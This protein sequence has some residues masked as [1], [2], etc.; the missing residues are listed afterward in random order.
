MAQKKSITPTWDRTE[1][2]AVTSCSLY[3]RSSGG[4]VSGGRLQKDANKWSKKNVAEV[5]LEPT[6]SKRLELE[7]SA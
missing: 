2:L 6:P 4:N 7:S 3:Q 5:G 1:D